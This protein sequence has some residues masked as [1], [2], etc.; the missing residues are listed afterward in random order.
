[1]R[2]QGGG[3]PAEMLSRSSRQKS[4]ITS[5]ESMPRAFRSRPI[6]FAKVTLSAW[7]A[8]HAYFSAS[9][10]STGSACAGCSMPPKRCSTTLNVRSSLTPTTVRAGSKKSCTLEPSRRNSGAIAMPKSTPA[11][12]AAACS[13]SGRRRPST[14]PG[15]T[16]LRKTMTVNRSAVAQARDRSRRRHA[17]CARR[18]TVPSLRSGVPTQ[19][20]ITS[21][22]DATSSMLV[23]TERLPDARPAADQ[24]RQPRLDH[25]AAAAIHLLD[26]QRVDVDAGH[27]MTAIC[28]TRR[29][30]S[31][32][33]PQTRPRRFPSAVHHVLVRGQAVRFAR[34]QPCPH[35]ARKGAVVTRLGPAP[36]CARLVTAH[37]FTIGEGHEAHDATICRCFVGERV[38]H[39]DSRLG[40]AGGRTPER[41][42]RLRFCPSSRLPPCSP[43]GTPAA[44]GRSRVTARIRRLSLRNREIGRR[45]LSAHSLEAVVD[46]ETRRQNQRVTRELT[47]A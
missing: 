16:V 8:L 34:L 15:G 39:L 44:S 25:W 24:I 1:M 45:Y 30:H 26:L 40:N 46:E 21:Q 7:Y 42:G 37:S 11:R 29:G 27:R 38:R 28:Q 33:V 10:A 43:D 19:T 47:T 18:S 4:R 22:R 14:V 9:A 3:M 31:A 41:S 12:R 17:R 13:M 23:V 36:N 5:R 20:T 2:T 6:S 35:L 32:N